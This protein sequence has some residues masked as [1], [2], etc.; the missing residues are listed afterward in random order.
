MGEM[1]RMIGI[2]AVAVVAASALATDYMWNGG[3]SGEWTTSA[4]WQPSTGYP[5]GADD[6]AA[7]TPSA[8][9]RLHLR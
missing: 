2:A 4:N 9:T 6:T 8:A 5:N 1:K 3:A 7:F